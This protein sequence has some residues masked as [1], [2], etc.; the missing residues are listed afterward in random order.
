[1]PDT[2]RTILSR[3]AIFL[4]MQRLAVFRI[5]KLWQNH[6]PFALRRFLTLFCLGHGLEGIACFSAARPDVVI[7]IRTSP[8]CSVCLKEL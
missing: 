1:M 2:I 3:R 5:R 4:N 8:L 6:D 7:R